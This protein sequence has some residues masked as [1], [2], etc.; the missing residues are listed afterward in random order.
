MAASSQFGLT[1]AVNGA[2]AN[3]RHS[4]R[5]MAYYRFA[6]A[7]LMTWAQRVDRFVLW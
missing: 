7:F 1:Y 2:Q 6:M 4:P 3:K 5:V